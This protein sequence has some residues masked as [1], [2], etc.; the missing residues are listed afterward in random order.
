MRFYLQAN[1]FE[2][3]EVSHCKVRNFLT[4]FLHFRSYLRTE[5]GHTGEFLAV[6]SVNYPI[7]RKKVSLQR[8]LLGEMD[9]L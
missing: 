4:W 6:P 5:A 2:F 7:F 1:L 8:S 9:A 3:A